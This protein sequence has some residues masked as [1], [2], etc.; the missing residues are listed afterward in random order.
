MLWDRRWSFTTPTTPR[1]WSA[2]CGSRLS[3]DV[4]E[5]PQPKQRAR[6]RRLVVEQNGHAPAFDA[7]AGCTRFS[8]SEPDA[9]S[10]PR[11]LAGAETYR[12]V[13]NRSLRSPNAKHSL[14]GYAW[15]RPTNTWPGGGA[16]SNRTPTGIDSLDHLLLGALYNVADRTDGPSI[17]IEQLSASATSRRSLRTTK[18]PPCSTSRHQIVPPTRPG[19]E[20]CSRRVLQ[21]RRRAKSLAARCLRDQRRVLFRSCT[22]HLSRSGARRPSSPP[23]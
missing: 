9:N 17:S 6:C 2:I 18:S 10:W 3:C 21:P 15:R 7:R 5:T 19:A 1:S 4:F 12:R 11:S 13:R 22:A 23:R 8:A 20:R 14:P 16:A